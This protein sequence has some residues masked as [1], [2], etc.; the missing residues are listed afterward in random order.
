MPSTR[1]VSGKS[2]K[3]ERPERTRSPSRCNINTHAFESTS[4]DVFFYTRAQAKSHDFAA[5]RSKRL[6]ERRTRSRRRDDT[7]DCMIL[8]RRRNGTRVVV[9]DEKL[10]GGIHYFKTPVDLLLQ[11]PGD[12]PRRP[13]RPEAARRGRGAPAALA[14]LPTIV[15]GD[16]K[17]L[18]LA[19]RRGG[20]VEHRV[21]FESL[22]DG[23]AGRLEP[24]RG[25]GVE[26]QARPRVR[27]QRRRARVPEPA[28]VYARA[29]ALDSRRLRSRYRG[30]GL[31]RAR[32]TERE[33][34]DGGRDGGCH[35]DDRRRVSERDATAARAVTATVR[36]RVFRAIAR[37]VARDAAHETLGVC[38][39]AL[40]SR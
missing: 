36:A 14:S 11:R 19:A 37:V 21:R 35:R 38:F 26:A 31:V 4:R 2:Q 15:R 9:P 28:R 30:L 12:E 23:A 27:R 8:T 16:S 13:D 5:A 22:V 25:E 1:F 34:R 7:R 32:A 20:F 39:L 40:L 10:A 29:R 33:A 17:R 24:E 3:R 18:Q 6:Y